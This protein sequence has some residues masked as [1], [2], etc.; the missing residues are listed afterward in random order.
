MSDLNFPDVDEP[1][2]TAI[3]MAIDYV[4][5]R[6]E[7]VLGIIVAGSILRGE[8][9]AHSDVDTFIIFEGDYR[10]RI[11]KFFNGV[12]FELF[13]NSVDFVPLYFA[14]ESRDGGASTAHMLATGH[15]ILK[16]SPIIDNL[17]QQ[18]QTALEASPQYQPQNL[19]NERYML[20]DTFENALD[21]RYRDPDMGLT[22][23]DSILYGLMQYQ[24]KKNGRWLPR[25]KDILKVTRKDYPELARLI[26][27][28]HQSV[29]DKR[30]E[31]ASSI[32]DYTIGVRGFFEWESDKD[33]LDT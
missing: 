1:V 28:Y 12:R 9:D 33:Y 16:R 8:G 14:E 29:G 4:L 22:L 24:F 15:I 23:L 18:A 31:I 7:N 26:A 13:G 30:Y 17:I 5:E 21:L 32:A 6:F 3:Q 10:Q 2:A 27:E 11:Q 20:A 25:H 19:I